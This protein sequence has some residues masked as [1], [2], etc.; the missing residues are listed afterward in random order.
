MRSVYAHPLLGIHVRI[1]VRSLIWI[2][3]VVKSWIR[4]RIKV[5]IRIRIGIGSEKL[6]PRPPTY[7]LFY[8][9][10]YVH[11]PDDLRQH[12]LLQLQRQH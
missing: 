3:I 6:D 11:L 8:F 5:N 1:K 10:L 12:D 9:Q 4:T 7:I 2:R